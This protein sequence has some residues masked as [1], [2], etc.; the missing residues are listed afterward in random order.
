MKLILLELLILMR[1][2]CHDGVMLD[3]RRMPPRLQSREARLAI[4]RPWKR[5]RKKV[6]MWSLLLPNSYQASIFPA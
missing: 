3:H 6:S 1:L 4:R 5:G 2:A